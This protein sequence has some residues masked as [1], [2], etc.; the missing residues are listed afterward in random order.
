VA[1]GRA[2]FECV[3]N[4]SEGR[5]RTV[6]DQVARAGGA[7]VLD[8][9][10]DPDHHRSVLTL[11]GPLESVE[12]SA[13]AVAAEAVATIDLRS[14]VGVHPR[15]GAV[16]VVPFVDLADGTTTL[17]VGARDRFAR[18]AADALGVPCFCY[19]PERSL[20]E[21]RRSAF[22]DLT[23]ST[24]PGRPHPTAGA[25]AV[26]ARPVLVAYN[27]WIVAGDRHG[28]GAGHERAL[29]VARSVAAQ[30]RG[31][32]VRS[33]GLAVGPGAQVSLNLVDTGLVRLADV[34]DDVAARVEAL[35]CTVVRAELVGLCPAS[36][37]A[38]TPPHRW[39]ELDLSEERTIQARMDR[40]QSQ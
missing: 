20:P 23:P 34:Y 29:S 6:I 17:A 4:I 32:G 39:A 1:P 7:C 8:V 19:G 36:V 18:W 21:V 9:H 26:G 35:G 37:L 25:M 14:H 38:D 12:S 5:G 11:G 33:L 16:D 10:V 30:V 40:L 27:V 31:P 22:G 2:P 13:R 28:S 24:G 15:L 3:I